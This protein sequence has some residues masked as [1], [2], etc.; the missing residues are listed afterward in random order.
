MLNE[1][2]SPTQIGAFLIA[3]RIQ[4]PKAKEL[5]GMIDI[6]NQLGPSVK[7]HKNQK[8][9]ICFGMPFDGRNR[10]SPVFPLSVLILLCANQPVVLQ[11]GE[12]MPVKYGVTTEE[13]FNSLG[14]NLKGLSTTTLCSGFQEHDFAFMYQ[15]DHFPLA[16]NLISYRDEI[17]KRPPIASMELLWTF[18]KGNHLIISGFVHTPTELR[19]WETLKIMGEEAFITIKGLEG[20]ID[21]PI[22]RPSTIGN[23]KEN[24]SEKLIIDPQEYGFKSKDLKWTD[25][26]T[27]KDHALKALNNEGPLKDALCWNAGLYLF[28]SGVAK[29][30]QAGLDEANYIISSKLAYEKLNQ[31]IEW[32]S[33]QE[34]QS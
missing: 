4:R 3:H 24:G 31:L 13:L 16:Q 7:S 34:V 19:H 25:I 17:G 18:H 27:W 26:N 9:P 1:V 20:G 2:P 5:A 30:I 12:R 10:T 22:S 29:D 15:P 28:L 21:I 32:R 33:K 11:G 14:L 23:F 8:R 6:Y